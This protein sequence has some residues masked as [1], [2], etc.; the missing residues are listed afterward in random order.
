MLKLETKSDKIVREAKEAGRVV[1]AT[2]ESSRFLVGD[3]TA[4]E[5]RQ[6][7][8]K[9]R[10]RY[11]YEVDGRQYT[12]R[13]T[14]MNEPPETL[15]LYYP[16][17]KPQKAIV[18]GEYILGLKYCI[19]C[20]IPF[21]VAVILHNTVFKGKSFPSL[22]LESIVTLITSIGIFSILFI[23]VALLFISKNNRK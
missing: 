20:S 21:I 19:I 5:W 3:P 6:R 15:T 17:N 22:K 23:V 18:E 10:V 9:Y 16:E 8:N 2:L 14:I 11:K 13:R 4:K 7:R 1:T 12:Y